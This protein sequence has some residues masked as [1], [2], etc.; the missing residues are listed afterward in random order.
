MMNYLCENRWRLPVLLGIY[1][2]L[3]VMMR[4]F[5]SPS[6]DFDESEQAFLAQG[7]LL[8][9][10]S[11]PPLYTWIQRGVFELFGCSVFSLALVKNLFL[12]MTYW[13]V[14]ETVRKASGNLRLATVATLGMF[15]IP[16]I[17]WE[18]HRDLSHTVAATFAAAL[19]WYAIV[20]LADVFPRPNSLRWYVL[21]GLAVGMGLTFKY[22]YAIVMLGFLAAGI[23]IPRY[24][25]TL[26]DRRI[27]WSLAIAAALVL[28]H[29]IWMTQHFELA[30]AKTV[31]TLTEGESSS[32]IVN[33]VSGLCSMGLAIAACCL[34]SIALFVVFF[35]RN[36][37]VSEG[38][39]SGAIRDTSLLLK[40]FLLTVLVVLLMIVLSGRAVEFKTRW[41]QPLIF[42]VPAYLTLAFA[43]SVLRRTRAMHWS[44]TL[45]IALMFVIL[46]AVIVRPLASRHRGE[47][48]WLNIPYAE[49]FSQIETSSDPMPDLIV[50][51]NM[52][53]AG[54]LKIHCPQSLLIAHDAAPMSELL[55]ERLVP[56][57]TK[58]LVIDDHDSGA[59]IE[60]LCGFSEKVLHRSL[61]SVS[62]VT[63][64][65]VKSHQGSSNPKTTFSYTVLATED[66][67][68][69][70]TQL[71]LRSQR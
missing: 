8:G 10:N 61:R 43:P 29:F 33:V 6:L 55:V 48:T 28:P 60:D 5:A 51:S 45:T 4:L 2:A 36:P 11:Q 30:S 54:N 47:Y 53:V 41:F 27:G 70:L 12:W 49:A 22:N 3:H 40:R 64:I 25:Q 46:A 7:M 26:L 62:G 42:L 35:V 16:Q 56:S 39:G 52:R 1:F 69:E 65:A 68:F 20:S 24:R 38:T 32:W 15:S 66:A 50:T 19:L 71:K 17:A 34:G 23:S 57:I 21:L 18:S 59:T 13:L 63:V 31:S 67:S 37:H 44:A 14:F 58:I 9:Y